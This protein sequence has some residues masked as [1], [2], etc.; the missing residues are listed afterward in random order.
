MLSAARAADASR[1]PD[2]KPHHEPASSVCAGF[3]KQHAH[4]CEGGKGVADDSPRPDCG[5]SEFSSISTSSTARATS[6]TAAPNSFGL[7]VEFAFACTQI[8]AMFNAWLYICCSYFDICWCR[9]GEFGPNSPPVVGEQVFPRNDAS[10]RNLYRDSK[11]DRNRSFAIGPIRDIGVI[12]I[13]FGGK[14]GC[15]TAPLAFKIFCE[16][17]FIT[18]A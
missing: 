11:L 5:S 1:W 15:R 10:R 9:S 7:R 14:P 8:V 18:L 17:H 4:C 6:I 3:F 2:T 12:S 13:N 16:L